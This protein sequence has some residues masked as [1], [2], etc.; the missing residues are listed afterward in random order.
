METNL[1]TKIYNADLY[2][3]LSKEDG[4]K[5]RERRL[6]GGRAVKCTCCS[7]RGPEFDSQH[8]H[9]GSQLTITESP[10][11]LTPSSDILRYGG[12]QAQAQAHI[13]TKHYAH[14][15]FKERERDRW[16][17][18]K[19]REMRKDGDILCR[20]RKRDRWEKKKH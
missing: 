18:V 4:D 14:N 11:N 15:F 17:E 7:P 19:N 1:N 9:G 2:L 12:T 10:G 8:P 3:R 5:D 6:G 13:L 20:E 16:R